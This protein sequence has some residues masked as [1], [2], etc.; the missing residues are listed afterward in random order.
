M[1][2]L[3]YWQEGGYWWV[4]V[5]YMSFK[6]DIIRLGSFMEDGDPFD[7]PLIILNGSCRAKSVDYVGN[8]YRKKNK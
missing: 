4:G 6:I 8:L 3:K 2:E 1:N 7:Q 5:N